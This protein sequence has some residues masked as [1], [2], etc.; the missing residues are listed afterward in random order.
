MAEFTI[1]VV[2]Q[3]P[4][5]SPSA[6]QIAKGIEL[7]RSFFP[8]AS[9]EVEAKTAEKPFFVT[10]RDAFDSIKCPECGENI[11]RFGDNDDH[12]EWWND[13]FLDKTHYSDAP[14]LDEEISMPCCGAAI[15]LG[16]I[17]LGS[18][19]HLTKFAMSLRD[20]DDVTSLTSTQ[21][22]ALTSVLGCPLLQITSVRS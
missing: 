2:A 21:I 12:D 16:G 6:D 18:S 20:P 8:G 22:A 13:C 4:T 11:E 19:A 9:Y 7:I 17:D 14:N 10:A 5:T 1:N 3:D 15:K